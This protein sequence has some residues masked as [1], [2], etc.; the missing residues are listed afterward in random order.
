MRTAAAFLWTDL[1]LL[2]QI[3]SPLLCLICPHTHFFLFFCDKLEAVQRVTCV[4]LGGQVWCPHS[5]RI[6]L[7]MSYEML[8]CVVLCSK[9]RGI[10]GLT[11]PPGT[12]AEMPKP[13]RK[14][15]S[16]GPRVPG[17]VQTLRPLIIS[18]V[19]LSETT[20]INHPVYNPLKP[21]TSR[22][23]TGIHFTWLPTVL[24]C[25]RKYVK[26]KENVKILIFNWRKQITDQSS[27]M[28][29]LAPKLFMLNKLSNKYVSIL[30]PVMRNSWTFQNKREINEN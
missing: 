14:H 16:T 24:S 15:W 19:T 9:C 23:R 20:I 3:K 6:Y 17:S 8:L 4:S 7:D 12:G 26:I 28:W 21:K 1:L 5:G 22:G 18:Y 10:F 2:S 29:S 27:I 25:P 30:R 13:G 11:N